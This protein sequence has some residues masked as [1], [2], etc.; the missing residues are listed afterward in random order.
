LSPPLRLQPARVIRGRVSVPGDKSISHR[1]LA[2]G[3]I[4]DADSDIKGRAQGED[5]ASM[6]R[7]LRELGVAIE[8]EG[9]RSLV[10]GVGLR[11]LRNPDGPLDCGNS[12]ATM[13]FLVGLLAGTPG[14]E[15]VLVGDSSLSRRPM[16][17]VA[18]PLRRMGALVETS[19]EGLPPVAV[20][21]VQLQG[22]EHHL[23]VPS[24]QVKT[25]ILLAGL[26]ASGE[27]AIFGRDTGRDHTERLLRQLG[28]DIEGAD[29]I[30]LR[31]P[32][33]I[34]GFDLTIPGD[35]SS[36]AF[37]L[38]LGVVH[39]DATV[40]T[41]GVGVNATRT[42]FLD[43]LR[44]MGA[45]IELSAPSQ[46]GG[47]PIATLSA[48][49]SALKATEIGPDEVSV[50][51]D[52]IPILAVAAAIADGTSVFRG[53]GELRAKEADRLAAVALELGRMGARITV[54][55]DDLVITGGRRLAGASVDSH[56][57]HRIAM[58][59]GVAAMIATG[60]TA[61]SGTEAVAVSYP[62]FFDVLAD[63]RRAI[64]G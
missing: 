53:L 33:S 51:L 55:G 60:E 32:A 63:L 2:L 57:D 46:S 4:A 7:C 34:A 30:R 22:A 17:R 44:R 54:N 35:T 15:A 5:Q 41:T 59:L 58:S 20:H 39:P 16:E 6:V 45:D 52:E 21:G 19:A 42:G 64:S 13:R 37:W 28:V 50:L 25:A 14:I 29:P 27:T 47:E 48:R 8:G 49:T 26:N 3:A 10:R 23:L 31:P 43:V 36:A 40:T 11:R 9:E 24:A 1:A 61:V 38:V 56:G 18:E 62:G 12:G